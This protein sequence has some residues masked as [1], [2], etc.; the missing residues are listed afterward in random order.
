MLTKRSNREIASRRAFEPLNRLRNEIDRL[1]ENPWA[2]EPTAAF[3]WSPSVD[4]LDEKD[5]ITVKA[6]IP[7]MK[8]EDI[9]VSICE[10]TLCIC[11]ERK[12]EQEYKEG[13]SYASERYFG[14]FERDIPLPSAVDA[15]KVN[16][17]YKDGVLTVTVPK[18]E[19][20]K[21]QQIEI[22]SS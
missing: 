3:G 14:R 15:N 7:G 1:F 12:E 5:K 11:G 19:Q 8:R 4:V 9:D 10:N 17:S 2:V 13:Q 21:R 18:T 22:K 6:E 20:A 16:A